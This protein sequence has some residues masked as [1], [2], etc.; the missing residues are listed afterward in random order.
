MTRAIT[1]TLDCTK[2][3]SHVTGVTVG[4]TSFAFG[5]A[6]ISLLDPFFLKNYGR[7]WVLPDH[8]TC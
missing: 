5:L 2:L 1:L 8:L 3:H 4:T 6:S 7:V